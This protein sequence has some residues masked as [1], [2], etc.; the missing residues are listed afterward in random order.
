VRGSKRRQGGGVDMRKVLLVFALFSCI[1]T[2]L[3]LYTRISM[4]PALAAA[5][6]D[7]RRDHIVESE[8]LTLGRD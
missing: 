1:G 4:G 7:E 3:L 8:T 2:M 6:M 5:V